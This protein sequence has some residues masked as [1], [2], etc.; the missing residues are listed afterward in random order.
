MQLPRPNHIR[1]G[2]MV[3][4]YIWPQKLGAMPRL[5]PKG[6]THKGYLREAG[7]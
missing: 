7:F 6:C 5:Q 1:L 4:P 3:R 2:P